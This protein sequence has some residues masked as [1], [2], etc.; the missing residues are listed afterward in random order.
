MVVTCSRSRELMARVLRIE[1][2]V[3]P[4]EKDVLAQQSHLHLAYT[5]G[6]ATFIMNYFC[7]TSFPSV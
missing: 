4:V 2:E 7:T 3:V 5:A 1:A 6:M